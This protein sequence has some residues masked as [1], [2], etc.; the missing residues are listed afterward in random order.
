MIP[1]KII[2]GCGQKYA[3]DFEP[4]DGNVAYAVQ[5]PVCGAD[6]SEAANQVIAEQT[7]A[8]QSNRLHVRPQSRTNTIIAPPLAPPISF[9][10]PAPRKPR[11]VLFL[12]G[13]FVLL[14]VVF[15]VGAFVL[16]TH[17]SSPIEQTKISESSPDQPGNLTQLNAWY[18]DPPQGQNAAEYY[19]RAFGV[20]HLVTSFKMPPPTARFPQVTKSTL[21]SIVDSNK[22]ALEFLHQG[23]SYEQSRYPLDLTQGFEALLPHLGKL[24]DASKL[25]LYSATLHAEEHDAKAATA[26]ILAA[27]SLGRSLRTEPLLLSQYIRAATISIAIGALEQVLNRAALPPES[28]RTLEKALRDLETAEARG[29]AFNRAFLGERAVALSILE[30]PEDYLK[31]LTGPNGTAIVKPAER[32]KWISCLRNT[33]ELKHESKF[34]HET[35]EKL[36]SA[37]KE[38]FPKRLG[39]DALVRERETEAKSLGMFL[40]SQLMPGQAGSTAKEAECIAYFRLGLAAVVLE[41]YHSTHDKQ[42][43]PALSELKSQ[44]SLEPQPD[45]FDGQPLRYEQKGSGYLIYSIGPNLSDDSGDRMRGKDIVFE[46]GGFADTQ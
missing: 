7:S 39:T 6:G 2:C 25:L 26:D 19:G 5:C 44:P 10:E 41:Q 34:Y 33:G 29:D 43:P 17:N 27:L 32:D 9:N 18:L 1:V 12:A 35:F 11:R 16:R 31:K 4:A 30:A 20:M 13:S 24:R 28:L 45:P 46:V 8:K 21:R 22:E 14:L 38:P 36:M 3:F 42:Y 23:A 37:R 40:N 15:S